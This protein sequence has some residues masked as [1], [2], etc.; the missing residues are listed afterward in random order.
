MTV[1]DGT[2]PKF[3][4]ASRMSQLRA[5]VSGILNIRTLT[6]DEASA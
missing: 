1:V 4:A 6:V 5:E 2:K 3:Y